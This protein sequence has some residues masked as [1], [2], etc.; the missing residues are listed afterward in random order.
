MKI[1]FITSIY[2]NPVDR[3]KG[4]FNHALVRSLAKTD[5]I[6]VIAP[7]SWLDELRALG[8]RKST[9]LG[10][11]R[12]LEL[13]GVPV[14]HPRY[15]YTPKV[16]RRLYGWFYWRSLSHFEAR[17]RPGNRPDIVVAFWAHPDGEAAVR[18]ARETRVPAVVIVGGSDV[19]ILPKHTGRRACVRRVLSAADLVL[20][21]SENLR[22]KVIEL[23]IAPEKVVLWT[24]GIDPSLFS[25]GDRGE[26][27]R[28]LAIAP[29]P[30]CL[31]WIG[32]MVPV[33]GLDVLIESCAKLRA[34]NVD[35]QLYLV[36]DGPSRR[37]LMA[38]SDSHGLSD[39]IRFVGQKL[40]TDLPDWYR[41]ANLTVLPSRSEGLPNVLRE[42]LACGTPFVASDVGG[43]KEI[44]H[45]D[46]SLLV[47]PEDPD[48][49]ALAIEH[50]L[51]RWGTEQA[52]VHQSFQS[53]DDSAT[54]L[55]QILQPLVTR[56]AGDTYDEMSRAVATR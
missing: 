35:Y 53:W 55:I 50:A 21:V 34:R 3:S 9:K 20:A 45:P 54:S 44:A 12:A 6:R 5:A 14:S 8:H 41:A 49:L 27:R 19:L 13:D 32:R 7:I 42:S 11:G 46:H 48:A 37:E 16:M 17:R 56:Q 15:Y 47:P 24:R 29:S 10:S 18:A 36:G 40:Q 31:V 28:R 2:P 33:K 22:S 1:L 38:K 26:A 25:P 43:I 52:R 23:G 39:Q 30:P 4:T 51:S